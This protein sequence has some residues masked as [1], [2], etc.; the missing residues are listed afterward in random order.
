MRFTFNIRSRILITSALSLPSA[1][2]VFAI[3]IVTSIN[4]GQAPSLF[5]TG[6]QSYVKISSELRSASTVAR[7]F[8][9]KLTYLSQ[10]MMRVFWGQPFV[11]LDLGTVIVS[12]VVL[13]V[14]LAHWLKLCLYIYLT[15]VEYALLFQ[16]L[17]LSSSTTTNGRHRAEKQCFFFRVAWCLPGVTL[18][19]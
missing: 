19:S 9:I 6:I 12:C 17:L 14:V 5:S 13:Q 4:N 3:D 7:V 16:L 2:I 1:T 8:C 15:L 11:L 18:C 10:S